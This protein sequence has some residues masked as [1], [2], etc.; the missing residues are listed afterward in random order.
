MTVRMHHP[1]TGGE[2]AAQP[3]QVE[4]LKA[5]G[6]ELTDP[7]AEYERWPAELQRFEGQPVVK[8]A[9]PQVE[10]D[11]IDAA[12]SQVPFFAERGW[13]RVDEAEAQELEDLTV[14]Q[15][16]EQAR[17]RGLPVSGTKAELLERLQERDSDQ[18]AAPASQESE[19]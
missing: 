12:E 16:K 2:Y 18:P 9:H 8:M 5:S 6:W 10:G 13:Q 11:P 14:E 7:N 1:E 3:S 17:E 15:L 19:E 4:F